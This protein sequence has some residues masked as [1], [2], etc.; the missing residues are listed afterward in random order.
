MD[1]VA[2]GAVQCVGTFPLRFAGGTWDRDAAIYEGPGGRAEASPLPG[3][4]D[5]AAVSREAAIATASTIWPRRRR[6]AV[7]VNGLIPSGP[8]DTAL[9][10]ARQEAEAGITCF[11]IKVE[12][13]DDLDRIAAIRSA[14]GA[15]V[16][17]RVDANAR[18]S[19]SE[20]R[21][22]TAAVQRFDIEYLED[23]VGSLEELESLRSDG[24]VRVAADM[25]VRNAA[26]AQR[27]QTLG[28]AD[29]LVV[30]VQPLGGLFEAFQIA[31]LFE[32]DVVVSSMMESSVGIQV[33]LALACALTREPLACG[34]GT[35]SLL[36]SDVVAASLVPS[37]GL[38]AWPS[39]PM[40]LITNSSTNMAN[41]NGCS[42]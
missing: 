32:G 13:E 27:A 3:Y 29:V 25:L 30:K 2:G 23:P 15:E 42:I 18:W 14:L 5:D 39:A 40:E 41:A 9:E 17:L 7:A 16:T 21:L 28:A 4:F 1:V 22:F 33:G 8:L 34:L 19:L 35:G 31:E 36:Q 37:G 6:D 26:D 12:G 11:K 24:T 10:R 38:L 20:A